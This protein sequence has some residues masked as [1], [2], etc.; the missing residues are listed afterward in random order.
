MACQSESAG[1]TE[2]M[3]HNYT[4]SNLTAIIAGDGLSVK[5]FAGLSGGDAA[6]SITT[7]YHLI[8]A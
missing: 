4:G 1:V 5:A 2:V 7:Y 8:N 6:F 3:V